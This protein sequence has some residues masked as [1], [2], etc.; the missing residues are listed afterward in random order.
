MPVYLTDT[1]N[2][3]F[4]TAPDQETADQ[5]TQSNPNLK[6][7]SSDEILKAR[8]D[9]EEKEKGIT[10]S[11][12]A[13]LRSFGNQAT[14]GLGGLA[15]DAMS[16][17]EEIKEEQERE[18]YHSLARTVGGIAGF[19][20]SLLYGGG[21]VNTAIHGVEGAAELAQGANIAGHI[22][23][24]VD[25]AAQTEGVASKVASALS[26]IN[27]Q[28]YGN[29]AANIF[30]RLPLPEVAAQGAL[31]KVLRAGVS[32]TVAG[33]IYATPKA[34]DDKL[35][36][37]ATGDP[38]AASEI[39]T[40]ILIN[41][42]LGGAIGV[43]TTSLGI[44][45]SALAG[46][47]AEKIHMPANLDQDAAD[48]AVLD[49]VG[50]DRD[51]LGK[52][53]RKT[54]DVGPPKLDATGKPITSP[55]N[56]LHDLVDLVQK[57]LPNDDEMNAPLKD[58]LDGKLSGSSILGD[59]ELTPKQQ[60]DNAYRLKKYIGDQYKPLYK[61]VDEQLA[62]NDSVMGNTFGAGGAANG[63]GINPQDYLIQPG[64]LGAA[65]QK[66]L[67]DDNPQMNFGATN[68]QLKNN[69][70]G[71]VK[72]LNTNQKLFPK[73]TTPAGLDYHKYSD[74]ANWLSDIGLNSMKARAKALGQSL[75]AT[76][77]DLAQ[78]KA[79]QIVKDI[80]DTKMGNVAK[81]PGNNMLPNLKQLKTLSFYANN[82]DDMLLEHK[83]NTIS[84][85]G[86]GFSGTNVAG[87]IGLM[88]G[89]MTANPA[90]IGGS[91]AYMGV[92]KAVIQPLIRKA[93]QFMENETAVPWAKALQDKVNDPNSYH[94][95][96]CLY[97]PK[98]SSRLVWFY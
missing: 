62:K 80:V 59:G 51:K 68:L 58:F 44:G 17:P 40:P 22:A 26:Y 56:Q 47:I 87:S 91:L 36:Q 55:P 2:G 20:A 10:G 3:S 8:V 34:I 25:T 79:Y 89:I 96:Q 16:T 15:A 23:Q 1:S 86:A 13:G 60:S 24:T 41:A 82:L 81:I 78:V 5:A 53:I 35:V 85:N 98:S 88:H 21:E 29:M 90:M 7:A 31:N 67:I 6:P 48:Y 39:L 77:A 30:D 14:L 94:T 46:K 12:V 37:D 65:I 93:G 69:I 18:K 83:L 11:I 75:E 50:F 92:N 61:T 45:A 27:P 71:L 43:G 76:N 57:P 73:Y 74:V 28:K 84:N 38:H 19:G 52:L 72:E 4:F 49:N 9:S 70:L 66:Q 33:A 64:E 95:T 63:N 97:W 42:L 32:N 54:P